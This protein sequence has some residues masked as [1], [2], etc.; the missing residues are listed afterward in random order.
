MLWHTRRNQ[1][2][3]FGERTSPFKLARASVQSTTGSRGVRIGG[4]NGSNAEYTMFRGSAKGTG[5]TL[6]PPVSPSLPLPGVTVCHHVS[7]GL[8]WTPFLRP[9]I[10]GVPLPTKPGIS[11]IILTPMEILQRNLNRSTFVV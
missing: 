10:Q 6:H 2:S 1:I 8:S 5:Y 7:T 4:S 11:L 9:K 3:S